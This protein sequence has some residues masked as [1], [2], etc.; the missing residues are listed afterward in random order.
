MQLAS[1]QLV[2]N[3]EKPSS[4]LHAQRFLASWYGR[5]SVSGSIMGYFY[6]Y[7]VKKP[8]K[9]WWQVNSSIFD[10]F[11]AWLYL[12]ISGIARKWQWQE[13][14]HRVA[15]KEVL[16]RGSAVKRLLLNCLNV[17]HFVPLITNSTLVISTLTAHRQTRAMDRHPHSPSP[18]GCAHVSLAED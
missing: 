6:P 7:L 17:K 8:W 14:R 5:S 2:S 9:P 1:C 3:L 15:G 12:W 16:L 18:R 11:L 10:S 4:S 13:T